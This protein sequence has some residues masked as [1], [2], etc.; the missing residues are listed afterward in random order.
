MDFLEGAII[1]QNIKNQRV[2]LHKSQE[3]FDFEVEVVRKF[4]SSN[5]SDFQSGGGEKRC[6]KLLEIFIVKRK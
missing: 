1:L 5:D 3:N 2:Y 6:K 4:K